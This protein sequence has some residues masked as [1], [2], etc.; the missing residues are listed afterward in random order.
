[1]GTRRTRRVRGAIPRAILG[2]GHLVVWVVKHPALLIGIALIGGGAAGLW[3][4]A[5]RSDAFRVATIELPPDSA[6]EISPTVRG[7]WLW[8]VD[9][10]TLASALKSQAPDAKQVRVV[11]VPPD[12]LRVEVTARQP[13]GQVQLGQWHAVDDRGYVFPVKQ[14]Q[15]VEGLVVLKG[16]TRADAPLKIGRENETE[17]LQL[18]LRLATQMQH[19]PMIRAGHRLT[20]IDVT[21]PQQLVLILNGETE[22]RCG[23]EEELQAQLERL[24]VVLR[25]LAR[26]DMMVDYI[27][28]RFEDPV[29]H[30]RQQGKAS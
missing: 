1:M 28:V 8:A 26:Q 16:V 10:T 25:K 12:T 2:C 3:M 20:T 4:A 22:V 17:R 29:V 6:L 7:Q 18:A 13:V 11:R 27:D 5:T 15:A 21:N 14:P 19:S 9:L 24:R 30:P 23:A